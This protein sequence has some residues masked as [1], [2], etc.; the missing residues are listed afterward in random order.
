MTGRVFG[1]DAA[2]L[3]GPGMPVGDLFDLEQAVDDGLGLPARGLWMD[4]HVHLG[5]DRDGH[6]LDL[7]GLLADL[8]RFGIASAVC[9]PPDDPGPGGQFA[10][11]NDAVLAAAAAAP[12]RVRPFCRLDPGRPWRD[13]LERVAAAGAC[14]IKLHPIAQRFRPEGEECVAVVRAATELGWPVLLHAGYGARPLA[15]PVAALTEAVPRARLILA[16]AGR[17]DA[18]ALAAVA[19]SA[20]GVVFDT[21]LAALPDLVAL[22]PGRLCFGSDR[23][24]GDYASALHLIDAAARVAG[25]SD[26][27]VEGVMWG[28]LSGILS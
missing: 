3:A 19:A 7:P 15:G 4:A 27:D 2:A 23:P 21:S 14:G 1:E 22:P 10:Q 28:N 8:E 13:E 5:R 6:T 18:R 25:W 11:A 26:R 17:G 9:F 16:H 24:Y 12:E 20:P